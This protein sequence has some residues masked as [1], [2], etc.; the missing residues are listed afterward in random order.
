MKVTQKYFIALIACVVF[1]ALNFQ[2]AAN[3][4]LNCELQVAAGVLPGD[5]VR[6]CCVY[7]KNPAIC[8]TSNRGFCRL[9]ADKNNLQYKFYE[10]AACRDIVQCKKPTG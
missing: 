4:P 9:N 1:A 7:K 5:E 6:G 10:G 8:S 2:A 3:E